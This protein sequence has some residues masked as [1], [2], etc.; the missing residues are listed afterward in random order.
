MGA[1]EFEQIV[2][3]GTPK[4][5]HRLKPVVFRNKIIRESLINFNIPTRL[6]AAEVF[7]EQGK[8]K[9]VDPNAT[10][11]IGQGGSPGTVTGIYIL[12]KVC[13]TQTKP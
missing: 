6:E 11:F 7:S 5:L 10:T 1:K 12:P 3:D 4:A 2:T 8:K 9:S 13:Q